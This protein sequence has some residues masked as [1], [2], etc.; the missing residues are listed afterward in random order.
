MEFCMLQHEGLGL[1]DVRSQGDALSL[2]VACDRL[3]SVQFSARYD[4]PLTSSWHRG[5][6]SRDSYQGP[7][8][9]SFGSL[10]NMKTPPLVYQGYRTCPDTSSFTWLRQAAKCESEAVFMGF[11]YYTF[12]N[13]PGFLG[14][15]S[16]SMSGSY[17]GEVL[18]IWQS[19][20]HA[21]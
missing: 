11:S 14:R 3:F 15:D 5:L 16:G 6:K 20:A 13:R 7:C 10:Q 21:T 9:Q 2:A 17:V 1:S 8:S 12:L 19:S 18:G 4:A